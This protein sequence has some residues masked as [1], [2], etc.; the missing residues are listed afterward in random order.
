[1]VS[2]KTEASL[3]LTLEQ[4]L[5]EVQGDNYETGLIKE[6]VIDYV[7]E[8]V[9]ENSNRDFTEEELNKMLEEQDVTCDLKQEI[10]LHPLILYLH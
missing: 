8:Y 7:R 10:L 1:M 2:N 4:K 6:A 9:R 5:R 3:L